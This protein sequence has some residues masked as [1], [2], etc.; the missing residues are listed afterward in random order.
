MSITVTTALD[1]V[2]KLPT[3]LN[4]IVV[5]VRVDLWSF[6][7][8]PLAIKRLSE[9]LCTG[10]HRRRGSAPSSDNLIELFGLLPQLIHKFGHL[11]LGDLFRCDANLPSL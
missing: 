5:L 2:N 6:I 1:D 10:L 3:L 11:L 8:A 4:S 9:W 7:L